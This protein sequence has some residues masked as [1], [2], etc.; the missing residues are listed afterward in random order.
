MIV[1]YARETQQIERQIARDGATR[2]HALERI[3]AQLPIEEKR[4][5]ADHV[6]DNSGRLADTERQVRELYAKLTA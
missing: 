4:K 3:R 2:E 1:V 5:L 6:I